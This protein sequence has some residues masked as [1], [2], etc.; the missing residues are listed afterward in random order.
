MQCPICLNSE[1]FKSSEKYTGQNY[2]YNMVECFDCGSYFADPLKEITSDWYE[3][4]YQESNYPWR[5]EFNIV[6]DY[7]RDFISKYK[8]HNV[9]F[10]DIGC[11]NGALL[12]KIKDF[13]PQSSLVGLDFNKWAI[14]ELKESGIDA[15]V[16]T[17]EDFSKVEKQFDFVGFFHLFEH[18]D[19]PN[20]FLK[21]AHDL[22]KANGHIVFSIPNLNRWDLPFFGFGEKDCPPHHLLRFSKAGL[23]KLLKRNG[24]EM[25]QFIE[26]PLTFKSIWSMLYWQTLDSLRFGLADKINSSTNQDNNH[27]TD[28]L[29]PALVRTFI[30]IKEFGVYCA[31]LPYAA[32]FYFL[33][34]NK[35]RSKNGHVLLVVARPTLI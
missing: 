34:F 18:I 1:K 31:A 24:F 6:L 27:E 35:L 14:A 17:L 23:E 26:E 30:K 7:I 15:Y 9:S 12:K 22:L 4:R 19:N 2:S 25:E 10:V 28:R 11:G 16:A 32:V 13:F 5:W 20:E 33:H 8:S 29:K 21:S 3:G